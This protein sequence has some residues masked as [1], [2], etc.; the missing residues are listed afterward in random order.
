MTMNRQLN[1]SRNDIVIDLPPKNG[2]LKL[3]NSVLMP[4]EHPYA[5]CGS[6]NSNVYLDGTFLATQAK[7]NGK[8]LWLVKSV[9]TRTYI[10][11]YFIHSLCVFKILCR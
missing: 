10:L 9:Y 1:I 3:N 2:S 6:K 7:I 8:S 5:N 11:C 4:V